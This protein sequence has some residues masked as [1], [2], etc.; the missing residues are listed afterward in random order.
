MIMA[1]WL[2]VSGGLRVCNHA[3]II[4][5]FAYYCEPPCPIYK[6]ISLI[7][8]PSV[9]L[10]EFRIYDLLF[11]DSATQ[12]GTGPPVPVKGVVVA[13]SHNNQSHSWLLHCKMLP[14]RNTWGSP[15]KFAYSSSVDAAT[16]LQP[17][18]DGASAS[19]QVSARWYHNISQPMPS[20]R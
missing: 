1:I 20:L 11:L 19:A 9:D 7:T 4:K 15:I 10:F 8:Q 5:K 17:S 16:P 3:P 12:A 2:R 13:Q 6:Y 18:T 14:H